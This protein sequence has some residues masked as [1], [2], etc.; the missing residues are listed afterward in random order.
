MPSDA[1]HNH[2]LFDCQ[3]C[4]EDALRDT[5]AE[6]TIAA[7]SEAIEYLRQMDGLLC[8][9]DQ[10]AREDCGFHQTIDALDRALA[11]A[12]IPKPKAP[13]ACPSCGS[14]LYAEAGLP[15]FGNRD[16]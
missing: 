16:D 13:N 11:K 15:F 5:L 10:D 3:G 1:K 6:T 14:R 12:V 9:C 8:S 4:V 2:N 7:Q